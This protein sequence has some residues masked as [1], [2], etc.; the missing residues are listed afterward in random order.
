MP[1]FSMF[2]DH[3]APDISASLTEGK[4]NQDEAIASGDRSDEQL[5]IE[6]DAYFEKLQ[7]FRAAASLKQVSDPDLLTDLHKR[8]MKMAEAGEIAKQELLKPHPE[9]WKKQSESHGH[10]DTIVHYRVNPDHSLDIRIETPIESSLLLPLISVFNE[11]DLY[12]TWMPRWNFPVKLGLSYSKCLKYYEPGHMIVDARIDM[13]FPFAN[14][15]C[16]QHAY[17]IDSIDDDHCILTK[18]ESLETGRHLDIDIPEVEKGYRRV[19]F[20]AC[21][22]FRACPPDHPSLKH[23]KHSYPPD[24]KLVL[25][26]L[27]EKADAHVTGV[28]LQLVNFFTRTVIGR[29]WGRL[30][31]IAE[32]V[33]SDKRHEHRIA[34]QARPELYGW[35]E[36][37]VQ[38]M[39]ENFEKAK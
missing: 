23:S 32:D 36:Q 6:A 8:I 21:I 5:I 20:E 24:E 11:S 12:S 17:S 13:P 18:V 14:R 30:L 35:V 37:R 7:Y 9:D 27:M 29:M 4:I 26:S 22:L 28:P 19:D 16:I 34:I 31:E 2:D 1:H 15:Q 33:R 10:R 39:F 3:A 25:V 38:V